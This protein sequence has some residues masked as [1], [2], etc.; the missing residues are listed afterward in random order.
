MPILVTIANRA[1]GRRVSGARCRLAL[2]LLAYSYPREFFLNMAKLLHKTTGNPNWKSK[3][4]KGQTSNE[5][6]TAAIVRPTTMI[7]RP[8]I[9]LL[10]AIYMSIVYS[11]LYFLFT[12]LT[13][14]FEIE[15][16]FSIGEAA[17]A[18]LGLG[19]GFI[20]GQFCVGITSDRYLKLKRITDGEM[21]PEHRLP[22]LVLAAFMVPIG[23]VW[24][25]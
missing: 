5:L 25:S 10:L 9:V 12:I 18:N 20:I 24:Y 3:Y 16:N 17:I 7:L 4:D 13:P 19:V 23:L 15:Y 2:D 6:F 22:P 8:P 1:C 14:V 21:K 11:Y